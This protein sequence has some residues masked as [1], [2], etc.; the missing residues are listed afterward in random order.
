M[1]SQQ[2]SC[3]RHL[4]RH[5]FL[6][7]LICTNIDSTNNVNQ[8]LP[9]EAEFVSLVIQQVI[10]NDDFLTLLKSTVQDALEA[11]IEPLRKQLES[12]NNG[13]EDVECKLQQNQHSY[14]KLSNEMNAAQNQIMN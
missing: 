13:I 2:P 3:L 12:I 5:L 10:Q 1:R 7:L 4:S 11:K 9:N 14:E 6:R 8:E